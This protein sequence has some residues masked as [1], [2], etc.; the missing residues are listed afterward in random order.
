MF[1]NRLPTL[2]LILLITIISVTY[3]FPSGKFKRDGDACA[4]IKQTYLSISNST[5]LPNIKYTDVKDCYQTFPY[6]STRASELISTFK[7]F[8]D[9]FY[10]F[11]NQAKESPQAGFSYRPV[12]LLNEL[13]LLLKKDYKSEF[14][15]MNAIVNLLDDLKD[16]HVYFSP[17]CYSAFKFDQG[18]YL[19]SVVKSD[20]TQ[21]IKVY[22]YPQDPSI[23]N[24]EVTHINGKPA[25]DVIVEYANT[26]DSVSRDL[27]VRFNNALVSLT[28]SGY[29]FGSFAYRT[30]LPEAESISYDLLCSEQKA[31]IDIP[32][33]ILIRDIGLFRLFDDSKSYFD[34]LCNNPDKS[35]P[36]IKDKNSGDQKIDAGSSIT[37]LLN[38]STVAEF[39]QLDDTGVVVVSSFSDKNHTFINTY[40]EIYKGFIDG[41]NL[42]AR[43]NVKKLVLD[44]TNNLGGVV[45]WSSFLNSLLLNR[46]DIVTFPDDIR[47]TN[48][49]ERAISASTSKNIGRIFNGLNKTDLTYKTFNSAEAFIGNNFYNRGGDKARFTNKFFDIISDYTL[50]SMANTPKLPWNASDMIVLTNGICGSSC[51]LTANFLTE[52]GQV[53]TVSVGG[54]YNKSLSYA[55]FVGGMV[56]NIDAI[57]KELQPLGINDIGFYNV[58]IL[59]SSD[60]TLTLKESY[61]LVKPDEVLEFQY[62]P[63]QYRLYYDDENSR[64]LTKLWKQAASFIKNS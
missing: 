34:N 64:D 22:D 49:S 44:F 31:R 1:Q 5:K 25:L 11:L 60:A 38:V 48:I 23:K 40:P 32:W 58:R 10:V 27:G 20:G 51:A 16:A 24:C 15:F 56:I 28:T 63:A 6:D 3:S 55:S 13:D 50:E 61:S 46:K 54:F 42:L 33:K 14:E 17:L 2:V 29:N 18:I 36:N 37:P 19:Y 41:F 8:Y 52:L 45:E 7:N 12:D 21:A 53:S 26:S 39:Y 35:F 30:R 43:A 4:N 62:R 57:I 59:E 47:V 9:N